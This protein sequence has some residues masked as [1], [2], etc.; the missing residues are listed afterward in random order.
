MKSSTRSALGGGFDVAAPTLA[1]L[2][3]KFI[4]FDG[5]DGC[6]KSTQ[7]A[8]LETALRRAGLPVTMAKDPGGTDIG[9]QIRH[10]LLDYDLSKMDVR[11]EAFLFMASRA[12]LVGEVIDPALKRGDVILCDRFISSTCAYQAAAGFD[13]KRI[14]ELGHYAVG[15]TWPAL[16]IILDLP[17]ELGFERT[18]RVPS[19]SAPRRLKDTVGQRMMFA[20]VRTDA[21]ESRPLEFHQRVRQLFLK[22][23]DHYPRPV[24]HVNGDGPR[25][26][27]HARTLEAI[28]RA[29]L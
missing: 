6:G 19:N 1:R 2:R 11:A 29:A 14:I 18:G 21:M 23:Q 8:L 7:L 16:T 17:P 5:P 12:Q 20:D 15:Q 13:A 28:E 25:D 22:L 3:G 9:N 10:I 26:A 24:V 4:V 27:V